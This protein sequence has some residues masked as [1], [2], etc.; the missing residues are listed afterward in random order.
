MFIFISH[1]ADLRNDWN[2]ENEIS[3]QTYSE[4][5]N[6]SLGRKGKKY[7]N[8]KLICGEQ[9]GPQL[10][11]NRPELEW[12]WYCFYAQV[13]SGVDGD[14]W[15][16]TLMCQC[17]HHNCSP[18]LSSDMKQNK[19]GGVSWE[20]TSCREEICEGEVIQFLSKL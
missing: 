19:Y 2:E 10:E 3:S 14:H 7:F 20:S 15:P 11:G 12:Y 8:A 5:I 4:L 9:K 16:Q 18:T 13:V 1:Y 17:E 6:W